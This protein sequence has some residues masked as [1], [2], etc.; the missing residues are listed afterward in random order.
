MCFLSPSWNFPLEAGIFVASFWFPALLTIESFLLQKSICSNP[1]TSETVSS[2]GWKSQPDSPR[3]QSTNSVPPEM[4][5]SQKKKSQ[6]NF[7]IF[8]RSTRSSSFRSTWSPTLW[9]GGL[10]CGSRIK[11][12]VRRLNVSNF[13]CWL[14]VLWIFIFFK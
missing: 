9:T 7:L 11:L 5:S 10:C 2:M 4:T 8:W 13:Y 6:K 12:Q 14:I 3:I 1:S